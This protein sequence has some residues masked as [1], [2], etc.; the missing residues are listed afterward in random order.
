M[1]RNENINKEPYFKCMECNYF[2][3]FAFEYTLEHFGYEFNEWDPCLLFILLCGINLVFT[4]L[5]NYLLFF[6]EYQYPPAS[7]EFLSLGNMNNGTYILWNVT[8]HDM[9]FKQYYYNIY[10]SLI[11]NLFVLALHTLCC[12]C[13]IYRKRLYIDKI[14]YIFL[15]NFLVTNSTFFYFDMLIGQNYVYIYLN[16]FFII[17]FGNI[18]GLIC[19]F[20]KHDDVIHE[21]NFKLNRRNIRNY[22]PN[23]IRDIIEEHLDIIPNN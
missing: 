22:R 5:Y 19:F 8:Q 21:M 12:S 20:E 16:M 15:F 3:Y 10:S 18:L 4:L 14:K 17:V 23:L 7:M 2:Y 6:S 9:I 11:I 13:R 1:W